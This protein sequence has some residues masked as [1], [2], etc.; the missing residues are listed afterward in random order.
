ML[1]LSKLK[2]KLFRCKTIKIVLGVSLMLLAGMMLLPILKQNYP[3][4]AKAIEGC[5]SVV[6]TLGS[7]AY[8]GFI[9]RG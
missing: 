8:S 1:T 9:A 7:G 2:K 6:V 3:G 4:A 5:L